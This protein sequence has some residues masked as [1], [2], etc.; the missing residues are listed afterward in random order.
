VP[1]VRPKQVLL[2]GSNLLGNAITTARFAELLG[3]MDGVELTTVTFAQSEV[4]AVPWALARR[5]H[6]LAVSRVLRGKLAPL[7]ARRFDAI[8]CVSVQPLL[9]LGGL[10]ASTPLVLW[11]DALPFHPGGGLRA[12]LLNQAAA[13]LYRRPLSRV[14]TLLAASRNAAQAIADHRF[15]RLRKSEVAY[16][17]VDTARWAPRLPRER[18]PDGRARVLSVANDIRRKGLLDF[19][20]YARDHK[21]D[22]SAFSFR[23]VTGEP[24]DELRGLADL[25]GIEIVTGASH[26]RLDELI[27]LYHDADIFFLPTKADMMPHVLLEACAAG[28]PIVAGNVG[29][30][31]EVVED[32]RTGFLVEARDWHGFHEALRKA[33]RFDGY[34][35]SEALRRFGLPR[36]RAILAESLEPG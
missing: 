7:R 31:S 16:A 13:M 2:I 15:P 34:D 12:R 30:I 26:A 25:F 11:F 1:G 32:G 21:L 18:A 3:G 20:A 28:L 10:A 27:A 14:T 23:I 6:A 36:L 19:F 8:V 9:A 29:A 24:N 33:A 22:L 35:N 17:G 5:F 4:D